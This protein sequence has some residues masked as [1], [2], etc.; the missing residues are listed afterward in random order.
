M[1]EMLFETAE[2]CKHVKYYECYHLSHKQDLP[3]LLGF[4][5]EKFLAVEWHCPFLLGPKEGTEWERMIN[6]LLGF[7]CSNFPNDEAGPSGEEA[8][9]KVR[10]LQNLIR[11]V[12]S[13]KNSD[14]T[15]KKTDMELCR[16]SLPALMDG[17]L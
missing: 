1:S 10:V 4:L 14:Q 15:Q 2:Y 6:S 17:N 3:H 5:S 9:G 8:Q 12:R 13:L 7:V 16:L 11:P